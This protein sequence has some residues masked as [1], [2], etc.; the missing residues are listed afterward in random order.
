MA[1]GAEARIGEHA[2]RNIVKAFT[3][4]VA[5]AID[6]LQQISMGFEF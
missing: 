6:S 4:L 2:N 1:S 3:R 5:L